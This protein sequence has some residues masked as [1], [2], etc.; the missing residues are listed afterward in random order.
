MEERMLDMETKMA[1]QENSIK[2]LSDI[3]YEQQKKID[4][5]EE[6]IGFLIDQFKDVADSS[7]G[8]IRNDKPPHY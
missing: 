8:E 7:G 4:L 2:E 5:L 6:K 1:Y 3:I